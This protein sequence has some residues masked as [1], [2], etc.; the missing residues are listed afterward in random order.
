MFK[1]LLMLSD[2]E[3]KNLNQAIIACIIS[4]LTLMLP[5]V[6]LLQIIMQILF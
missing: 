2:A 6:I 4:N 3:N 5:F 1:K